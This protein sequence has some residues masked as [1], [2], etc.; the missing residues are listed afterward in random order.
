M[1]DVFGKAPE[2]F[3]FRRATSFD[4]VA[5]ALVVTLLPPIVLY[6]IEAL[7]RVVRRRAADVLHLAL[8]GIL[9]AIFL[10]HAVKQGISLRGVA[11]GVVAAAGGVGFAVLVW[12]VRTVRTWL[13]F[14]SIAPVV[15]LVIFLAFSPTAALLGDDAAATELHGITHPAPVVMLVMDE[16]PT[17][18]LL[19]AD[20]TIDTDRYPNFGRLASTSTWYRNATTVAGHTAHA[21]PALLTGTRPS[22]GNL[23]LARDHPDSLFTLLGGT[24][25]LDVTEAVTR[26]CPTNLCDVERT[27]GE[28]GLRD[29][30]DDAAD[31]LRSQVSLSDASGPITTGFVERV[32]EPLESFD[33]VELGFAGLADIEVAAQPARFTSFI[34]SIEASRVPT[35][36]YLHLMLPHQPWIRL[37]TGQAI[38]EPASDPRV[39]LDT[40]LDDEWTVELA[41]QQ[42]LLQVEYVD[43]LL[44]EVLDRLERTGVLDDAVVVVTADHGVAFR[45]GGK[46][47]GADEGVLSEEELPEIAWVPLFVKAPGQTTG[48]LSDANVELVDV[49]PTLADYLGVDIPWDVDG[50]SLVEH[51]EGR[52]GADKLLNVS[53]LDERGG[54]NVGSVTTI[55]G[56]EALR[57]LMTRAAAVAFDGPEG[58]PLRAYRVGPRADLVGTPL[59]E[60]RIETPK[61]VVAALDD[62][63]L[64][65]AIDVGAPTIPIRLA[66]ALDGDVDDDLLVTA[67]NGQIAAVTPTFEWD[68]AEHSFALLVPPML[69]N[70]GT[71]ELELLLLDA[72]GS[73][74]PVELP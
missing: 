43:A 39:D 6:A 16:F 28:F 27:P 3:V 5:F 31:V 63:G 4:I 41:R 20:G 53:H 52:A 9:A 14:V 44:G 70:A 42:H 25:E 72:T 56:N 29:L 23:P 38:P 33:E 7:V 60:L 50:L 66:G 35:L 57:A 54:V 37:P 65:G 59:G 40:W 51:P 13:A 10:V 67:V 8:L 45:P 62:D 15:F 58:D 68:G 1:L 17:L 18:S 47:R 46:I 64:L 22:D 24:Y 34:E 73:A 36:D 12:R 48:V 71:N 61:G 26:V 19:A 32:D 49:L 30:L 21:V 2:E 69:L 55:D 74:R 11:L